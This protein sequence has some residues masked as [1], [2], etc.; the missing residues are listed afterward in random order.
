MKNVGVILGIFLFQSLLLHSQTDTT[1]QLKEVTVDAPRSSLFSPGTKIITLDSAYLAQFSGNN[2]AEALTFEGSIALKLYGSGGLTS[3]SFRGASASQT[4]VMWNGFNIQNPMY[5]QIDLALFPVNGSDKVSLQYGAGA[6]QIGSGAVSGAIVLENSPHFN[7]GFN[8]GVSSLTGSFGTYNNMLYTDYGSDKISLSAKVYYNTAENNFSFNNTALAD[9][10]RVQQQHAA[11]YNYGAMSR[12]DWKM[13]KNQLLGINVWYQYSDREIPTLM[14]Q[15]HS[16]AEQIDIG[17]KVS[18]EWKRMF[19]HAVLKIRSGLFN[20]QLNYNDSL[21]A[22][23]TRSHSIA[24]ISEIEYT[25]EKRRNVVQA[26][27]N[28]TYNQASSD[29]YPNGF[30]QWRYSLF[31]LYKWSTINQRLQIQASVRKELIGGKIISP[32]IVSGNE[33][34]Y[35]DAVPE[36]TLGL[37]GGIFKWL[38]VKGNV[39][40]LYRVP[41]LN[42]LYWNPGGNPNLKPEEGLSEEVTL[43]AAFKIRNLKLSYDVTYFNRNVTNWIIWLP[44][45]YYWSP[46]NALKVWSRGFEHVVTVVYSKNKFSAKVSVNYTYTLSTNQRAKT[47]NDE[48]LN[49]Q[50]IYCPVHQGALKLNLTYASWYV[51]YLQS[52]T[53]YRYTSTD[54]LEYLPDYSV[55]K[56]NAGKNFELKKMTASIGLSCNNV[57]DIAY[58]SVLWNAMPGRSY[59]LTLKINFKIRNTQSLT[60]NI[61]HP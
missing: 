51:T 52:Y 11:L 59:S 57:F 58:Q 41:T 53:G 22:L 3:T 40:T 47:E 26:G 34:N 44:G 7:N 15:S 39:S 43:A 13:S 21:S 60:S 16:A 42:D 8:I 50:L 37:D 14:T 2:L 24:S 23:Y 29:G 5:G 10:P 54:N 33:R 46:A 9:A 28:A 49:K 45:D 56:I 6:A 17:T 55:T 12:F 30:E 32:G 36:P 48:S 4:P 31:A 35:Y 20:D 27:V 18:A 61:Q 1:K 38:K 19:T 25:Y